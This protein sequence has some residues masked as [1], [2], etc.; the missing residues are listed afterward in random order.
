MDQFHLRYG[1]LTSYDRTYFL[2]RRQSSS[3]PE[4]LVLAI[5]NGISF[6]DSSALAGRVS[7]R[8]CMLGLMKMVQVN[9]WRMQVERK[10]WVTLDDGA[11]S[12][13]RWLPPNNGSTFGQPG[14]SQ[15]L[16]PGAGSSG[17]HQAQHSSHHGTSSA[18]NH[19]QGC[20]TRNLIADFNRLQV[21]P[22]HQRVDNRLEA[23]R[24]EKKNKWYWSDS[25][26]QNWYP[27]K[28]TDWYLTD[29]GEQLHFKI[30]GEYRPTR[31]FRSP[32]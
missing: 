31:I 30:D 3:D 7:V 29:Q 27:V 15:G 20:S 12:R 26:R 5:S 4:S 22:K 16:G 23:W 24:D 21:Q 8:E 19:T 6:D 32:V 1:F 2:E 14:P 18:T 25:R 9:G 28:K 10:R 17:S 11:N 13:F